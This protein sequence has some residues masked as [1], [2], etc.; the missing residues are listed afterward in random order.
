MV[1]RLA[2]SD[3]DLQKIFQLRYE[4]LRKPWNQSFES[5]FDEKDKFSTNVFIEKDN[6]CIACGRLDIL[7][8][9]TAQIR[10][11]AVHLDYRGMGLG[12]KI[13]SKLEELAKEKGISKI[14]LHARENALDFYLLHSYQIVRPSQVLFNNI[15]HYLMEKT[16][17][18]AKIINIG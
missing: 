13:L 2:Q 17:D 9:S 8:T 5:S 4:V 3:E 15:Q 11:M 10:Y 16:L 12:S 6:Q 1:V 18:I 14:I 7:N